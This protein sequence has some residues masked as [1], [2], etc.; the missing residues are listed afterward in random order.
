MVKKRRPYVWEY[1]QARKRL[2]AS[3][4][5][6]VHCRKRQATEADHQP[7][8]SMH[9][10]IRGTRC[11]E[12]VP[13]CFECGRRQGGLLAHGPV[14]AAAIPQL[15]VP[16]PPGFDVDSAVWDVAWLDELREVPADGWWPRL[17]TLPHPDAVDSLGVEFTAW[18]LAEYGIV[19]HWWQVLFAVRLLEVDGEGR[20]VWH[21][22]FLSVARQ[23][24]KSWL[25]RL[26][27]DWRSEQRDRF[28]EPQ[29]V[30][31][32]A[33]T[34]QHALEV[35]TQA[36]ERAYRLGYSVRL[37]QGSTG[38]LKDGL[39][40]WLV[41]SQKGVVGSSVS[42]AVADEAH[43]VALGTVTENLSPT[44]A[45]REQAQLLLV[46]TAHSRCT[47]LMPMFRATALGELDAPARLLLVEWSAHRELELGDL[48]AARQ[49]SP[50]WSRNRERLIGEAVGR[51][52]VTPLGHELRVGADCQWFNRW[53]ALGSQ[54][55][56]EPLLAEGLW[57][58]CEGSL[59]VTGAG[60][61][62]LEDNFGQGASVA[63]AALDG[64]ARCE[65]AGVLCETWAEA[66]V[67][68]RK[69]VDERP[70]SHVIVAA[71]ML[72]DAER[73]LRGLS[74]RRSGGSET[75]VALPLLRSLV[76]EGRVVHDRTRDL[77]VQLARARVRPAV[78]GLVLASPERSDLLRAACWALWFAQ[79]PR[80]V[81]RAH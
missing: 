63:F 42:M 53:P 46:S 43:G 60:W 33:D 26:L 36:H 8:I 78:G 5:R 44:M 17:M 52:Q 29:L 14:A 45:E 31:H 35:Q 16:D 55:S 18:C 30:M 7:P 11:C 81:P 54:V 15:V 64:E 20:L 71:S 19:L 34:L 24:G 66:L 74:L 69:F 79:K 65:V 49:A 61:V 40:S 38:I 68:A 1:Q 4:P 28:G 27:C 12:I 75:K 76:A 47:D 2:L 10:H 41:R 13:S 70:G 37:A 58:R 50:H 23:S 48:V 56:G 62:A 39:G 72:K 25:L 59:E 9:L 32:T 57:A 3:N 22:V 51:A 67:W 80:L 73:D 77:D 6:C 21:D